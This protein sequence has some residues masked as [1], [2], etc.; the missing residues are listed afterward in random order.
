MLA[1]Y[2]EGKAEFL[3]FSKIMTLQSHCDVKRWSKR[4][5][6]KSVGK[7]T[8]WKSN[9]S[10]LTKKKVCHVSGFCDISN[11]QRFKICNCLGLF[12][13]PKSFQFPSE[14][15]YD[16]GPWK[17]RSVFG[18]RALKTVPGTVQNFAGLL[19]FWALCST[20]FPDLCPHPGSLGKA[21]AL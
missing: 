7:R 18:K 14:T 16:S 8:S 1:S 12:S 9:S 20:L 10:S 19:L 4:M 21:V 6:P 17:P 15:A 13:H 2:P 11:C 5:Q 3:L